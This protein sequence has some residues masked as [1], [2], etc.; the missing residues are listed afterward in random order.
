MTDLPNFWTGIFQYPFLFYAFLTGILVSVACG[1]VGTYV[2]TRRITYIAGSISH[3]VLGGM[4]LAQYLK[5]VHHLDFLEPLHGAVVAALLAALTIGWVSLHAKQREDTV[6]GALWAIGMAVGIL[7]IAKTPGY[8]QNLMSYLFGNILLV[9]PRE[10]WLIA[11][12]D[13][14]VVAL[15]LLFYNQFLAICFD[16]EFSS[17]RGIPVQC[18]YLLLLCLTALTVVLLITV[19][20]VVMV[21]ALLTLPVA[22]AGHFSKRLWHMMVLSALLS[23][24]FTTGGLAISYG[25]NLPAGATIILLSGTVYLGVALGKN[26]L[27]RRRA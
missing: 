18:F 4:G 6:I 27:K 17:L 11:S 20:G 3:C 1:V 13:V 19:V 9:S 8:N 14:F 15:G 16:E 7:F 2:V 5:V 26:L 12:L 22:I 24:G 21:I 25:S 10:L 23:V